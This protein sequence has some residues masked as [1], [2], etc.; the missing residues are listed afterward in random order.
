MADLFSSGACLILC[1]GVIHSWPVLPVPPAWEPVWSR[2]CGHCHTAT[3][4][5][6]LW[7][8]V[9]TSPLLCSPSQE[10][11]AWTEESTL[12]PIFK[13]NSYQVF[14]IL[15]AERSRALKTHWIAVGSEDPVLFCS[16]TNPSFRGV[17]VCELSRRVTCEC[18]YNF[19]IMTL[20]IPLC[21]SIT[22]CLFQNKTN[23]I[24][25]A[26]LLKAILQ[27]V[28]IACITHARKTCISSCKNHLCTLP[29]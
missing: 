16:F 25:K 23:V 21:V 24:C 5:A 10:S 17:P 27:T 4:D 2:A 26:C 14:F 3:T 22:P 9:T 13:L 15:N 19:P 12:M 11:L 7:L 20:L 18:L 28:H 1:S 8:A 29:S 6:N